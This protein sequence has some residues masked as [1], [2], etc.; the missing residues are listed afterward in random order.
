MQEVKEVLL[1]YFFLLHS[2]KGLSEADLDAQV[3]DFL[4]D[5]QTRNERLHAAC[6][7]D[8]EVD[9]ALSK[10]KDLHLLE[11]EQLSQVYSVVPFE[12]AMDELDHQ[13]DNLVLR[14]I[15]AAT[16]C[17]RKHSAYSPN[18]RQVNYSCRCVKRT[19]EPERENW[20]KKKKT[21]QQSK[22]RGNESSH[23]TKRMNGVPVATKLR[24]RHFKDCPRAFELQPEQT[25]ARTKK[26]QT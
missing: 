3:E 1:A 8:F 19:D 9:D 4:Q 22:V 13:W 23:A 25:R 20:K 26:N 6:K 24:Q 16:Y 5:L 18:I 21:H 2:A 7:I 15:C 10:L 11:S 17:G 14:K 12:T